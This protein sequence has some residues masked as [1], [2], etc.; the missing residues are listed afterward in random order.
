MPKIPSYREWLQKT[1]KQD[2]KT[3]AEPYLLYINKVLL[4]PRSYPKHYSLALAETELY[5][6]LATTLDGFAK[7]LDERLQKPPPP[8]KNSPKTGVTGNQKDPTKDSRIGSV[9]GTG[10]GTGTGSGTGSGSTSFATKDQ[11]IQEG[12]EIIK[13]K[14]KA[15]KYNSKAEF[16]PEALRM[17]FLRMPKNPDLVMKAENEK[18]LT[19][20]AT[21]WGVVR[22]G[23]AM[24]LSNDNLTEFRR[25]E[26]GTPYLGFVRIGR[27]VDQEEDR[28]ALI[29][30]AQSIPSGTKFAVLAKE[31][32]GGQSWHKHWLNKKFMAQP[33]PRI[34][35]WNGWDLQTLR[36]DKA[37]ELSDTGSFFGFFLI[38][39]A[40][41]S[42]NHYFNFRCASLNQVANA[43]FS[44]FAP[45]MPFSKMNAGQRMAYQNLLEAARGGFSPRMKELTDYFPGVKLQRGALGIDGASK[46]VPLSW[47]KAIVETIQ[48]I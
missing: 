26:P 20:D 43:N 28:V 40:D 19:N 31:L 15:E 30:I 35:T 48:K 11:A 33:E 39:A 7:T 27:R 22:I 38:K 3:K 47:A 42:P 2:W 12:N 44:D 9:T 17:T 29:Q 10:T 24:R 8:Q 5:D 37:L 6:Q 34:K 16:G 4:G 32:T 13:A 36:K 1:R 41:D 45:D 18:E 23:K 14:A 21:M 25:A 46:K